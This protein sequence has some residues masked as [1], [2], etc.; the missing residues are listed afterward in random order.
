MR[1]VL[2]WGFP[3][4]GSAGTF[5]SPRL[6]VSGGCGVRLEWLDE[7]VNSV[8]KG[9]LAQFQMIRQQRIDAKLSIAFDDL[10]NEVYSKPLYIVTPTE[11]SAS[12]QNLLKASMRG[13]S[14]GT[15]SLLPVTE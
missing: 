1:H 3:P 7:L 4:G 8:E 15:L 13:T 9:R 12:F 5:K 2:H 14:K 11:L 10:R 6:R